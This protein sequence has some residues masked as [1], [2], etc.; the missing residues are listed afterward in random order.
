MPSNSKQSPGPILIQ[1][2]IAICR[3]I[4]HRFGCQQLAVSLRNT[5]GLDANFGT[6]QELW[7]SNMF[8]ACYRTYMSCHFKNQPIS[9]ALFRSTYL[10]YDKPCRPCSR[11]IVSARLFGEPLV[12]I[13]RFS[14]P[15]LI[16]PISTPTRTMLLHM[17]PGTCWFAHWWTLC[18]S[19]MS[20]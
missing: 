20:A 14:H 5:E 9:L 6:H 17:E 11:Y 8:K 1:I 16:K 3:H 18:P 7:R 2:Y 10:F 15:L 19:S 13:I 4:N 12:G